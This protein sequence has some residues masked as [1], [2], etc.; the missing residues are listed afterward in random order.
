MAQSWVRGVFRAVGGPGTDVAEDAVDGVQRGGG[1]E[2]F[3]GEV[4]PGGPGQLGRVGQVEQ[5]PAVVRVGQ[6]VL[7]A[8]VR[9]ADR[10]DEVPGQGDAVDGQ[11]GPSGDVLPDQREHD[12]QAAPASQHVGQE[13][14]L[15]PSVVGRAAVEAFPAAEHGGEQRGHLVGGA[16]GALGDGQ[17][18]G[19]GVPVESGLTG[20]HQLVQGGWFRVLGRGRE[21]VLGGGEHAEQHRVGLVGPGL[22]AETCTALFGQQSTLSGDAT[23]GGGG[24]SGKCDWW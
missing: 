9:A 11:A 22:G 16:G 13:R 20:R 23:A 21:G 19:G 10:D 24:R 12:R 15:Q 14:G 5:P 2:E 7:L 6:H 8:A 4:V 1:A 18:D 3:G 17:P